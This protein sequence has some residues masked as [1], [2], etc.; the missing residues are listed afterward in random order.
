MLNG[1]D[2]AVSIW[3]DLLFWKVV[4]HL[5]WWYYLYN[6]QKKEQSYLILFMEFLE[7]TSLLIIWMFVDIID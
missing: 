2:V 6:G 5:E 1:D 4:P 7:I 3:Q